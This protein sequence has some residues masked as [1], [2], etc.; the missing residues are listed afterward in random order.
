MARSLKETVL[1]KVNSRRPDPRKIALAASIL[2]NGG[3]VAFPTETVYGLA[4]DR[5]NRS[6]I[7]AL[8]QVK[9]RPKG[10]PLT[11]HIADM[12][13][14]R[15]MGCRLSRSAKILI[16]KYWPGPLTMVLACRSG[17]KIGFRM[18]DNEVALKLIKSSGLPLVA[19]SA[20]LSGKKPPTSAQD[21]IRDLGGKIDA[22]LD[23]GKTK[24]GVESTVIDIT[25]NPPIILREG[26]ISLT[27]IFRTLKIK[28]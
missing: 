22:V 18:P 23:G 28:I 5:S 15:K 25:K 13:I 16:D 10:K 1:L 3:L 2:K 26:A 12:G 7:R 14:M 24:V 11:V 9:E 6:A 19:P 4:A 8:Y 21:V 27:Q 20:N 17:K